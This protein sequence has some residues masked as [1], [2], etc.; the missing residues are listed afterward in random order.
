[1][2]LNAFAFVLVF[3]LVVLVHELGHFVVA[4]R[5]GIVIQEFGIG[6]PPRLKTLAVRHGV[7]YTLNA[8]PIGGF[9]RM[10]G[11]EDP[12]E[13]GS[14]AS[15]SALVR[16]STLLA[17]SVMNL[18]L[19]A[20]LFAG[21]FFVG[22]QVAVG[23]VV[24][25][26]VAPFSPAEQAGILPGDI[27]TGLA[28]QEIRNVLELVE[29][30][31]AFQGREVS[32]SLL[33]DHEQLDVRLTPRAQ[34]PEGE[35]AM[36]VTI[37]MEPGYEVITERYP[38]WEAIYLGV[39]EVWTTLSLMITGLARMFRVGVRPGDITGPVGIFEISGIVAQT[40][41]ANL[42]RFIGFFSIN[43]SMINMLPLPALDGG[44]I[45]FI[46]LEKVRG[47]RRVA[48]QREGL[49]HFVGLLL[50]LALT[51]VIS[52]FDILRI[53]NRGALP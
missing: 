13:P 24:V 52:Y 50:L 10:L 21:V 35:G 39:R 46:L 48:P 17:G 6:Y 41:L 3:G 34:P 14:F 32:V 28:G 49:V 26:T 11:E 36:G 29:R 37:A 44:R 19:A 9:V 45:A 18:V 51:V 15:K 8:I 27:V 2:L 40:G 16:I 53:L 1:M 33:R 23:K 20:V 30:T 5:G 43:L 4:R 12:S 31:Q 7:E 47:G 38:I 22:Q 25:E 42:M